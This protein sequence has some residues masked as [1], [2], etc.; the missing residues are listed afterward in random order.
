MGTRGSRPQGGILPEYNLLH[1]GFF[2]ALRFRMTGDVILSEAKDPGRRTAICR[3]MSSCIRDSSALCLPTRRS[4]RCASPIRAPIAPLLLRKHAPSSRPRRRSRICPR[5]TG[6]TVAFR[7]ERC[8]PIPVILSASEGS[9]PQGGILP[10]HNLLHP[11]FFSALRF[12]MTG[13]LSS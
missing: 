10:E 3:S 11:G 5:M 1:P 4:R 6:K 8:F 9:R 13:L 2:S 7:A 12:R